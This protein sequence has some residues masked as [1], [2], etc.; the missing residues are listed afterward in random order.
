MIVSSR[1]FLRRVFLVAWILESFP[2]WPIFHPV[3]RRSQIFRG[4]G[5][6]NCH[7]H[8]APFCFPNG[9]KRKRFNGDSK[10]SVFMTLS[11][12][13]C[14]HCF[15]KL[16]KFTISHSSNQLKLNRLDMVKNWQ[17]CITNWPIFG[18]IGQKMTSFCDRPFFRIKR[19]WIDWTRCENNKNFNPITKN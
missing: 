2:K 18:E 11:S 15:Q 8:R 9:M 3:C 16:I 1:W 12:K 7:L 13:F 4:N 17:I 5:S 14:F 10:W 6:E 19:N